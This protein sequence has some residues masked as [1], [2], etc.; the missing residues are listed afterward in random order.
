VIHEWWGLND[1]V[2]DQTQK[3]AEQGF[4]VLA[5]DLYGGKVATD[6]SEAGELLGSLKQDKTMEELMAAYD[7]LNTR[8]DVTRDRMGVLGWGTGASYALRLAMREP[9][10]TACVVNYG[11]LPTDPNDILLIFGAVLGNFGGKD[12]G[13][14]PADA[15]AFEKTMTSQNKRVD[16]KIYDDAGHGF[17]YPANGDAYRP[18]DAADAWSRS[19]KFLNKMLK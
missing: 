2:K 9:R 17:E 18:E 7:Y 14:T 3:L 11:A 12:R 19:V 16:I 13:I 4:V 6:P 10:M 8:K 15:Q 5:V 1:W